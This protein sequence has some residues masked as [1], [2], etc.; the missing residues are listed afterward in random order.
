MHRYKVPTG[1]KS[2]AYKEDIDM[3]VKEFCEKKVQ[4]LTSK[5]NKNVSVKR[6]SECTLMANGGIGYLLFCPTTIPTDAEVAETWDK[7]KE[8]TGAMVSIEFVKPRCRK[9]VR[10][11]FYAVLV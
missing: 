1:H 7:S 6:I 11:Y 9:P 8:Y 4:E 3:T 5:G 2:G 10:E